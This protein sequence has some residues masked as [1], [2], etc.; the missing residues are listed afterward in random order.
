MGS[1]PLPA[2][3]FGL[4]KSSQIHAHS[5]AGRLLYWACHHAPSMHHRTQNTTDRFVW[6]FNKIKATATQSCTTQV[7]FPK[8]W[9]L[10]H[11]AGESRG[12]GTLASPASPFPEGGVTRPFPGMGWQSQDVN[13]G[14]PSPS[15][16]SSFMVPFALRFRLTRLILAGTGLPPLEA[17]YVLVALCLQT[18]PISVTSKTTYLVV[19]K[20][21]TNSKA[22]FI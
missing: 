1:L 4:P 14:T 13:R 8:R 5:S 20:E 19:L 6:H 10:R 7:L 16:F 9:L 11:T 18:V 17:K 15:L 2:S 12:P 3:Y 21:S 22:L